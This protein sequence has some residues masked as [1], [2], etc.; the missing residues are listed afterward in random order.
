MDGV[1]LI[2]NQ[3]T[4]HYIF[5]IKNNEGILLSSEE[6]NGDEATSQP[7]IAHLQGSSQDGGWLSLFANSGLGAV[8]LFTLAM[9][10]IVLFFRFLLSL[11]WEKKMTKE[12]DGVKTL[13]E[14]MFG[15]GFL[16]DDSQ[17]TE[18]KI[19]VLEDS[20]YAVPAPTV[21]IKKEFSATRKKTIYNVA[22]PDEYDNLEQEESSPLDVIH[23]AHIGRKS[24]NK[25][26]ENEDSSHE[27]EE[28]ARKEYELAQEEVVQEVLPKEKE[29]VVHVTL[30]KPHGDKESKAVVIKKFSQKQLRT[31][32]PKKMIFRQ[33]DP[34]DLDAIDE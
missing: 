20:G 15:E 23:K 16:A 5:Y 2:E 29:N 10:A 13:E 8:L 6:I 4:S 7:S 24:Y 18:V 28:T 14:E 33:G 19:P 32:R 31:G 3:I 1:S 9:F 11:R 25:P 21:V 30:K 17:Q 12:E 27:T 22:K 34:E 26:T